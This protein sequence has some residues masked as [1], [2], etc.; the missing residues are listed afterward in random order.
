MRCYTTFEL[1]RVVA[2]CHV[3]Y[4]AP[5]L[6]SHRHK[7][8]LLVEYEGA[9]REHCADVQY[10]S[11]V[12]PKQKVR[13]HVKPRSVQ[14]SSKLRIMQ[15]EDRQLRSTDAWRAISRPGHHRNTYVSVARLVLS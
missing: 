10:S 6:N 15:T 5:N 13:R 9:T 3:C 11:R 2:A 4:L 1:V 14:K 12:P 7:I 8:F